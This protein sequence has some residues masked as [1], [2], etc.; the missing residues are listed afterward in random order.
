M[1]VIIA[2]WKKIRYLLVNS[3]AT[4]IGILNIKWFCFFLLEYVKCREC[5]P[6]MAIT[7]TK[8][9]DSERGVFILYISYKS[10]K[11]ID[12]KSKNILFFSSLRIGM[13]AKNNNS[14]H[15]LSFD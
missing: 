10:V 2:G 3:L 9:K 6:C 1:I 12:E 7:K 11:N 8:I 5:H 15:T 14:V 4:R 13:F